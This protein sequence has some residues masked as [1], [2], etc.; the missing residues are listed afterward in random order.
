MLLTGWDMVGQVRT[1]LEWFG[2]VRT[3]LNRYRHVWR[4]WDWLHLVGTRRD[5]F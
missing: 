1:G 3:G 2:Q 4:D 5:T